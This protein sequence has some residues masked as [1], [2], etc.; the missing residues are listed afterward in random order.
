M[1]KALGIF[2]NLGTCR[3]CKKDFEYREDASPY[4]RIYCS[5]DCKQN[6]DISRDL[7][8]ANDE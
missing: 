2:L 4:K 8:V 3:F 5:M 6:D 1:N 7:G